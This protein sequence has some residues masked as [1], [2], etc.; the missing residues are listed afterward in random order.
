[1]S[2]PCRD[3][4]IRISPAPGRVTVSFGGRTI[5]D[6]RHA[7]NL[8]EPGAPL[9]IYIP[10]GDVDTAFLV[11]SDLHTTCPYKGEASYYSLQSAGE[12]A[13]DA[14]WYYPDPCALVA[15][16]KDHL[17]FWGGQIRYDTAA[18]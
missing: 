2:S 17:A 13:P 8:D 12:L 7:L 3:K 15:P 4:N 16:I 9:R 18:A 1:M 5:A 10:R 11:A 6:T 14:V